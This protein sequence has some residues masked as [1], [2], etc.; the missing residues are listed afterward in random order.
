MPDD[1]LVN[2][3]SRR[4][5]R[6]LASQAEWHGHPGPAGAALDARTLRD[7]GRE[8][9]LVLAR[10]P[11]PD[12][13]TATWAHRAS[14]SLAAYSQRAQPDWTVEQITELTRLREDAMTALAPGPGES[15]AD[16][17][18]KPSRRAFP[19]PLNLGSQG[20]RRPAILALA[21]VSC[22][23]LIALLL[24]LPHLLS[25]N[26]A[27]TPAASSTTTV[28]ATDTPPTQFPTAPATTAPATGTGTA[29][30]PASPSAGAPTTP[31]STPAENNSTVTAIQINNV[32]DLQ[33]NPP[34]AIVTYT[35]T[36]SGTGDITIDI[37]I[38]GSSGQ[39]QVVQQVPE[40][41]DTSYS[42][43][44]QT[45]N[46]DQWCGQNSVRLT[47]SSGTVSK[48]STVAISGC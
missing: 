44:T 35:I 41:D 1:C 10:A 21:A 47:I 31:A 11:E 34:E 20:S 15:P 24:T 13:D 4:A 36:A 42:D 25:N 48:S 17:A 30:T 27:Q 5:L 37:S 12:P 16:P 9:E 7:L 8:I 43:L 40:S 33:G 45:I 23:V 14:E 6:N 26:P 2:D 39:P 28:P 29:T 3:E 19:F 32:D 22:L 46:L 38:T 18:P